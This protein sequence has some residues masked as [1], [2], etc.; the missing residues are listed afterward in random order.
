MPFSAASPVW[1]KPAGTVKT[2]NRPQ[3]T[4]SSKLFTISKDHFHTASTQTPES[5]S[6]SNRGYL[7]LI[8]NHKPH[9]QPSSTTI[10]TNTAPLFATAPFT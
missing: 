10:T 9:L 3:H 1:Y 7:P 8:G 5:N 6:K 2:T 4:D